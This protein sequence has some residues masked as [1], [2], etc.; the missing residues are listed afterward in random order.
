MLRSANFG[1]EHHYSSTLLL[2]YPQLAKLSP[3]SLSTEVAT[4]MQASNGYIDLKL[5]AE[6]IAQAFCWF[7]SEFYAC[8]DVSLSSI[9]AGQKRDLMEEIARRI[10]VV[11]NAANDERFDIVEVS[12]VVK[13]QR[14]EL[15]SN[16][17][18]V[19]EQIRQ[20]FLQENATVVNYSHIVTASCDAL[21]LRHEPV[22]FTTRAH[23]L[24][25][26]IESLL[27]RTTVVAATDGGTSIQLDILSSARS[28]L[29][30]AL[31]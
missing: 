30:L 20:F 8:R 1:Q 18:V 17:D 5:T 2:H 19:L 16:G 4:V 14:G 13:L 27:E 9:A 21:D 25:R 28:V 15:L 26:H 31:N 24:A 22:R 11:E 23:E 7:R 3:T 6:A 10:G 29:K 12:S